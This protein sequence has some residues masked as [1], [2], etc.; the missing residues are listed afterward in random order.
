MKSSC[1]LI[2]AKWL[3][4]D[5]ERN[6]LVAC[7]HEHEVELDRTT[8]KISNQSICDDEFTVTLRD[9]QRIDSMAI[10]PFRLLFPRFDRR[11]AF[12]GLALISHLGVF[13]KTLI[14]QVHVAAVFR[15]DVQRDRFWKIVD[16][17]GGFDSEAASAFCSCPAK[18]RSIT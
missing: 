11:H 10:F 12:V 8:R 14:E 13:S 18:N 5:L 16:H 7:Q 3:R 4:K 15:F 6:D 1:G 2:A 17:A 9:P